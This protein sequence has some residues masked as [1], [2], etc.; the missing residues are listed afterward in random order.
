MDK[1][2]TWELTNLPLNETPIDVK[3]VSKLKMNPNGIID[4]RKASLVAYG[5]L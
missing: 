5:F 2:W 3:W 4:K 1:T